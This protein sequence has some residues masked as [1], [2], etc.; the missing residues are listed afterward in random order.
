M[1]E[2]SAILEVLTFNAQNGVTWP[3]PT[4]FTRIFLWGSCRDFDWEH[5]CQI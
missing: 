4:P 2:H 5:A 1:F 3:W